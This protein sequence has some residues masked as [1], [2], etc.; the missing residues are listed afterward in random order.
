MPLAW[1]EK[2]KYIGVCIIVGKVLTLIQVQRLN[3]FASVNRIL[4]NLFPKVS[5]IIK[6]FFCETHALPILMYAV[7]IIN[8]SISYCNEIN[9]WC[10]STVKCFILINGTL[11]VN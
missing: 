4:S 5:D 3:L 11:L 2:L 9:S 7:E 6:L 10:L 8:L 1:V